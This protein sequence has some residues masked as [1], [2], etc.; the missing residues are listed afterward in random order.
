MPVATIQEV[1][2]FLLLGGHIGRPGA[3]PCPIRGHSN[4]Q[5]DRTMGIWERMNETFMEKLNREFQFTPPKEHGTDTVET[6][7][8]MHDGKIRFFLGMGGNFLAATPDTE[9]NRESA[10]EMP[11]DSPCLDEAKPIA[12]D[13]GRSRSSSSL[14]S[15]VLRSMS[16][17]QVSNS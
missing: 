12:S 15:D 1:M 16:R 4:V 2:N 8:Q 7:K 13:H 9:Y 5:G 14:A 3:G 11:A 10:A 17:D 6:I